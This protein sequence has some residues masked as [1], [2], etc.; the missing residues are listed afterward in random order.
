MT[1]GPSALVQALSNQCLNFG[2]NFALAYRGFDF[3]ADFSGASGYT[4]FQNSETRWPFQND[5]NLNTIFLDR[6]H[7]T[8]MRDPNSAWI[9]GKYPALRF[10]NGEHSNYS[11]LISGPIT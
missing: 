6:W 5:G 9:A 2:F 8:D 4:W 7:R 1:N 3:R 11:T 10:N